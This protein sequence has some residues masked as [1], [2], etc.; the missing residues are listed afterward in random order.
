VLAARV[1]QAG[2]AVELVL[3][4]RASELSE[5][6][7]GVAALLAERAGEGGAGLQQLADAQV[8]SFTDLAPCTHSLSVS[9]SHTLTHS[10]SFSLQVREMVHGLLK[11]RAWKGKWLAVID[12][13]ADPRELAGQGIA[14]LLEEFPWFAGKTVVTSRSPEWSKEGGGWEELVLESFQ[15]EEAIMWVARRMPEWDPEK[16]EEVC[17]VCPA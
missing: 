12:D 1:A 5:D 6:Y 13:A 3:F 7:R 17:I 10:L 4:L 2:G 11:S 14:W 9:L 8:L 15:E 16:E